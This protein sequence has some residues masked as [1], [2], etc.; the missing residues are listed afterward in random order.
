M[1]WL[2][3]LG[4]A[5][6][7]APAVANMVPIWNE[8]DY[9][10]HGFLVG[11]VAF[12]VAFSKRASLLDESSSR[13]VRGFVLLAM[14]LGLYAVGLLA[15]GIPVQGL[16][17]VFA[18]AGTV[19][20]LRG[21]GWLRILAFPIG[22]LAFMIPLPPEWIAPLVSE[23]QVWVTDVAVGI[24]HWLALPIARD[25]N[26]ILVPGGSLFVAEACSGITSVITLLPV[27]VLL[28][29]FTQ[30]TLGRRLLLAALIVPLAMLGNLA[31]VLFTVVVAT[32]AGIETATTGWLHDAA[33]LLTYTVACLGL[34]GA[35]SAIRRV[36][37][38][39]GSAAASEG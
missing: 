21:P 8:V 15:D 9:F 37:P 20:Y 32:Q 3:V 11:P 38:P 5:L 27:A 28:G 19:L 39:Q 7:F 17:L 34:I 10:A 18:V 25:G 36:W 22:Y 30:P 4:V 12:A 2:L 35:D 33:G 29:Y 31:R 14:A 23:L 26:V 13:D 6:A 1:E 16:A 24:S